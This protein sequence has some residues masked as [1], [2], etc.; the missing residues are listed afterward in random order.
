MTH[1][2]SIV[3]MATWPVIVVS[4][5]LLGAPAGSASD[6]AIFLDLTRALQN[7]AE[8]STRRSFSPADPEVLTQKSTD[9]ILLGV[10]IA[11]ETRLA[12]VQLTASSGGPELVA[13]GGSLGGYRL[14]DV[15][16]NQVTLE[17]QRG[18]RM[19]LRL[20]TG[21]GAG[22]EMALSGPPGRVETPKPTDSSEFDRPESV[23][24]KEDRR[25]RRAERDAQEKVRDLAQ[26]AASGQ[27]GQ[28]PSE[29]QR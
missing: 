15:E 14:T 23:R 21:G 8:M 5:L 6:Q 26:R 9:F 18:E 17:G 2:R 27:L 22:G 19:I 20:Q 25:A 12:L 24:A 16:E 11:G 1:E 29:P 7:A 4:G 28:P 3:R 13:V 10:A